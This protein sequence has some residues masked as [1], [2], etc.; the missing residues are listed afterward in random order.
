MNCIIRDAYPNM[1]L[2]RTRQEEYQYEG[3]R[4]IDVVDWLLADEKDAHI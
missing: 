4:I 3:V 1:I 2:T